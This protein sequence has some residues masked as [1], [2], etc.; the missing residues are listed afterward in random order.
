MV[1][2]L[3]LMNLSISGFF[4][5]NIAMHMIRPGANTGYTRMLMFACLAAIPLAF[6]MVLIGGRDRWPLLIAEAKN[7]A[8]SGFSSM[9]VLVGLIILT[10]ILPLGILLGTWNLMGFR[11]GSLLIIYLIP[12]LFRLALA[13]AD[14]SIK[15]GLILILLFFA[16]FFVGIGIVSILDKYTSAVAIYQRHLQMIWPDYRDAAKLFFSVC[17]FALLNQLMEFTRWLSTLLA[18]R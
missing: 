12:G 18:Q 13:P 6:M 4:I 3:T 17:V 9:L 1:Q 15:T 7:L 11:F 2:F 14:D 5:F 8:G 16:S 10:I